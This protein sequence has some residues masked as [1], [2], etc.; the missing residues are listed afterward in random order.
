[1]S[2]SGG[3]PKRPRT[4]RPGPVR[5]VTSRTTSAGKPAPARSARP[6][7]SVSATSVRRFATRAR[8]AHRVALRPLL[9]ALAAAG[10]VGLLAWVVLASPLLVARTVEVVGTERIPAPAVAA[11][12]EA[13]LGTPLALMDTGALVDRVTALPMVA[14][15]EAMRVWPSTIEV[16]VVE[17]VPLA[18]VPAPEG[19]DVVDA[20]GVV[21]DVRPDVPPDLPLVEVDVAVAGADAL[22]E[23]TAVLQ[24]LPADLRAQVEQAGAAS[25][26]SVTLR[27]RGGAQVVWGSADDAATK[28]EVLRVL[29]TTPAAVYDVS[30]PTTP[31]TR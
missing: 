19:F 29:M 24:S 8:A 16:R 18:A 12:A 10:V 28:A 11:L 27:L 21:V 6:R 31:V 20:E 30:S 26:D 5:P 9:G 17:R 25:R 2:S 7:S 14:S 4:S 1:M 15:A 3:T 13:D 22:R 23:T